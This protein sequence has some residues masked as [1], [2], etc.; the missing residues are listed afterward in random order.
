MIVVYT[1]KPPPTPMLPPPFYV[2]DGS[3][4]RPTHTTWPAYPGAHRPNAV[5]LPWESV[6]AEQHRRDDLAARGL[7]EMGDVVGPLGYMVVPPDARDAVA[8]EIRVWGQLITG[9]EMWARPRPRVGK[10]RVYRGKL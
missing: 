2:Q 5:L 9:P 4:W 7:H 8:C 3:L 1:I 10:N 6:A